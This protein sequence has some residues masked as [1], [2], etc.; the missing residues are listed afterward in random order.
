MWARPACQSRLFLLPPLSPLLPRSV[1]GAGGFVRWW[2][3][4]VGLLLGAERVCGAPGGTTRHSREHRILARGHVVVGAAGPARAG[5]SAAVPGCGEERTVGEC[6]HKARERWATGRCAG[7][8]RMCDPGGAVA[9]DDALVR[10]GP[11]EILFC[12][13]VI[14]GTDGN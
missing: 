3:K 8:V 1:G 2:E 11:W 12:W 7:A 4:R 10:K 5:S 14:I 13:V 9:C 6:E